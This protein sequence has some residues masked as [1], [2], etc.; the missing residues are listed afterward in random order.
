MAKNVTAKP[1]MPE[2]EPSLHLSLPNG[3]AFK[4]FGDLQI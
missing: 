3:G 1:S 2:Q 4:N